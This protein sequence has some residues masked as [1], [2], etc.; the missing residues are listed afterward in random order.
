M[1]GKATYASLQRGGKLSTA[2]ALDAPE[3][4]ALLGPQPDDL[5]VDIV[6]VRRAELLL[7]WE[8]VDACAH[9][10]GDLSIGEQRHSLFCT[11]RR[12]GAARFSRGCWQLR[13]RRSCLSEVEHGSV[14]DTARAPGHDRA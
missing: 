7:Q 6:M 11:V 5:L 3:R 9:V 1:L 8:H 10:I 4:A 13:D 12:D 2:V 14:Q